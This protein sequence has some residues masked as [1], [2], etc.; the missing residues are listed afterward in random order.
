M[1]NKVNNP[2]V[3]VPTGIALNDK[4]CIEKLLVALKYL[5]KDM[6]VALTEAS[7]EELYKEYKKIFDT[8]IEDQRDTFELMFRNGWY[9][10][11]KAGTTKINEKVKTLNQEFQDLN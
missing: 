7:N 8:I 11:E 6:T 5:S 1:N 3:E 9:V 10:L 4:D 2:K